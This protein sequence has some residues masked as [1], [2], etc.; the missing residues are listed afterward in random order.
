MKPDCYQRPGLRALA[1]AARMALLLLCCAGLLL[2]LGLQSATA[3][4]LYQDIFMTLSARPLAMG[5]SGAALEGPASVFYNPAGLASIRSLSLMHN[6][7]GRHFP[8]SHAG[9]GNEMDQLDGDTQAVVVPLPLATY[10]HGFTF[11]GEMGYD[12]RNH[13]RPGDVFDYPGEEITAQL[14]Y[15]HEH[16]DGRE[17]Y[18]AIALNL[19]LPC[20]FGYS[21]RRSIGRF[22]PPSDFEG[23]QRE[24]WLYSAD[25]AKLAENRCNQCHD[26]G[27]AESY[28][29][30]G[31]QSGA[32][33][34]KLRGGEWDAVVRR[35]AAKPDAFLNT[36]LA[37]RINAFL[38]KST[39]DP[40]KWL[41]QDLYQ[42]R[43]SLPWLRMGEGQQWGLQARVWPGLTY[44]RS[45]LKLDYDWTV[46]ALPGQGIP[47]GYTNLNGLK[48][49]GELGTV[50]AEGFPTLSSRL[51]TK[52][53]GWAFR[54]V[55]WLTL[56]ADELRESYI[57]R[58]DKGLGL[59]HEGKQ[60]RQS[61]HLGGEL[62]LGQLGRFRWGS[63]DGRPTVGG[64]LNLLGLWV[65]Y[66]EV[67]DLLP[68]IVGAGKDYA[69][70]HVYGVEL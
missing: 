45:E 22:S 64:A 43:N 7:S 11:S 30:A 35:M 54:P 33:K 26:C 28:D 18:D 31:R 53:S 14:G 15:P 66:S 3:L 9:R 56:S 46:L 62:A 6:H 52:R 51:K 61:S 32:W 42:D 57:F 55:G 60:D 63:Y 8:G 36:Y 39:A 68:S 65:N 58:E 50:M 41:Q 1:S 23:R 5:G 2:I 48:V 49:D 59:L 27:F 10:A 4:N 20:A 19:G 13:P 69:D 29:L 12:Y 67:Q 25:E 24:G 44:G 40:A 16:Y 47:E 38:T 17:D 21:N 70:V 34:P 37:Q